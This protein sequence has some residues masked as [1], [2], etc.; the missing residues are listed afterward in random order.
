[1]KNSKNRN[2]PSS[3]LV[4]FNKWLGRKKFSDFGNPRKSEV[5]IIKVKHVATVQ[6]VVDIF[7]IGKESRTAIKKVPAVFLPFVH[8]SANKKFTIFFEIQ[9]LGISRKPLEI[10]KWCLRQSKFHENLSYFSSIVPTSM[11]NKQSPGSNL[12]HNHVIKWSAV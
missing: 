10:S 3:N 4:S 5:S 2:I 9:F 6:K 11:R 8:A 7:Q 12:R 1:M